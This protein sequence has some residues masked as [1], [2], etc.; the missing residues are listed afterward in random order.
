MF[1]IYVPEKHQVGSLY[2]YLYIRSLFCQTSIT[3]IPAHI[4]VGPLGY[5]LYV[6]PMGSTKQYSSDNIVNL[7]IAFTLHYKWWLN[8]IHYSSLQLEEK[9]P[10]R[11][12]RY[13]WEDNTKV[14][15]KDHCLLMQHHIVWRNLLQFLSNIQHC[16]SKHR[17]IYTRL[18]GMTSQKTVFFIITAMR[19]R[20]LR[21]YKKSILRMSEI[22]TWFR[23]WPSGGMF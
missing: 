21:T 5:R 8:C 10:L 9:K 18:I 2:I 17:H 13:R 15:C 4:W 11:K 12:P 1:K 6:K 3:C 16:P 23:R 19:N 14:G 22:Y 7:Y 20:I